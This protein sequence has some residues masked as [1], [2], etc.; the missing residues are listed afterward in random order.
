MPENYVNVLFQ[1]GLVLDEIIQ[2]L[3]IKEIN[4][5]IPKNE[6]FNVI[7]QQEPIEVKTVPL[8]ILTDNRGKEYYI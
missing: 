1:K 3:N 8:Y 6:F 4:M 2:L 5:Q 7:G